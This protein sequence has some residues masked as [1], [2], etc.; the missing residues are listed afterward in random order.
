M[1]SIITKITSVI[2]HWITG[3]DSDNLNLVELST[4]LYTYTRVEDIVSVVVWTVVG[5]CILAGIMVIR[6]H[7]NENK[8]GL[9]AKD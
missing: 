7:F 4:Y 3:L 9:I 8:I 5:V 1:Y 2:T 6:N